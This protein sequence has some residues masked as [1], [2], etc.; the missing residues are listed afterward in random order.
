VDVDLHSTVRATKD[1]IC[2]AL[3]VET[4]DC[5]LVHAGHKLHDDRLLNACVHRHMYQSTADAKHNKTYEAAWRSAKSSVQSW[6]SESKARRKHELQLKRQFRT[7]V[8]C[9]RDVAESVVHVLNKLHN[10]SLQTWKCSDRALE[11]AQKSH[12]RHV[13]AL[14][15]PGDMCFDQFLPNSRHV[16]MQ[17]ILCGLEDVLEKKRETCNS[18][19][20]IL[21]APSLRTRWIGIPE[22]ST[23]QIIKVFRD[24]RKVV[25]QLESEIELISVQI[26]FVEKV[27]AVYSDTVTQARSEVHSFIHRYGRVPSAQA[28][29]LYERSLATYISK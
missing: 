20:K 13:E 17:Q 8:A 16:A 29:S 19:A 14:S 24:P 6:H 9:Q 22:G 7:R 18:Y 25:E 28:A 23:L 12:L 2:N 15:Y 1:K 11:A 5:S 4:D 21:G 27:A 3:R 10:A 26:R